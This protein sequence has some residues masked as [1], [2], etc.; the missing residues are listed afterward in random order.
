MKTFLFYLLDYTGLFSL[1]NAFSYMRNENDDDN[2]VV[3][4][5]YIQE[6]AGFR[7]TY[8]AASVVEIR[9]VFCHNF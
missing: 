8:P 4:V 6:F 1:N 7:Y 5:L 2:V 3:V 9:C